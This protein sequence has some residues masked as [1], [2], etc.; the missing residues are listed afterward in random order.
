MMLRDSDAV[1]ANAGPQ[2]AVIDIG[3]NTVRLVVY[4][5]ARRAPTVLL[6]EKV[7]ARLGRDLA[8]TGRI[9]KAASDLAIAGISRFTRIL[10]DLHIRDVDCIATAAPREASNGAA[11]LRQVADAGVTPRLLS[12]E[13]EA[14]AAAMG[15][16]GAFPG[17][18]GA[19]ADLGGGSLELTAVAHGETSREASL[20]LGTLRLPALRAGGAEKFKQR[21]A[22][23]LKATG[24]D[25]PIEG[26]LYLVGGTWRA[27][28]CYAMHEQGSPIT[29]PHGFTLTGAE[30]LTLAKRLRRSKRSILAAVPR[31][32]PMRAAK[33]PDAGALLQV[34]L[35]KLE[36]DQ[37]VVSAWGLREG[38]LFERLDAAA[39][40]Q[41]PLLAGVASFAAPRGGPPT[42]ATRIAAWTVDA[43]PSQGRGSERLRLAATMLALASMQ[44]EPNLR[45]KQAINWAL[46]KRWLCVAPVERAMIAAAL[47]ANCGEI[48]L[49][50]ILQRLADDAQLEEATCWGL[51]I[52]LCRRLGAGSRRSL[53][54]SALKVEGN[55]L[56]LYLGEEHAVLRAEHVEED[57]AALAERLGLVPAIEIV[58]RESLFEAQTFNAAALTGEAT[59]GPTVP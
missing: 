9:P 17:A 8:E 12:G 10:D 37:V 40:S 15:V 50:K 23:H 47:A 51:A 3:S 42:L 56:V 30:A 39:R 52:R 34:L 31:V 18:K 2:R 4:G 55:R 46:Y 44:I 33:L 14:R 25:K 20:P 32:S 5:G 48:E 27:L 28:A 26:T 24:W 41:D 13:E 38:V 36:P 1:F 54:N 35:S 58:P 49:P 43:V 19:I 59:L 21:I 11:F 45:L 29:D 16:I 53:R 7:T 6:N 22:K 57:L